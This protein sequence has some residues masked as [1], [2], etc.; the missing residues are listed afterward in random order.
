[1]KPIRLVIIATLIFLIGWAFIEHFD[2]KSDISSSTAIEKT[3]ENHIELSV[4][5]LKQIF[6]NI[7]VRREDIE[8]EAEF[9]NANLELESILGYWSPIGFNLE[10]LR[11]ILG[12]PDSKTPTEVSYVI[13]G[14]YVS[15]TATFKI[16]GGIVQGPD[17]RLDLTTNPISEELILKLTERFINAATGRKY[18]E[19]NK[20]PHF[21]HANSALNNLF[22]FWNPDGLSVDK[23]KAMIGE[24]DWK[25]AN[26]FGYNFDTGAV[27]YKRNFIV[28]EG[29]VQLE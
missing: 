11:E 20:G 18:L 29:K 9:Y 8:N 22:Y 2:H 23:L 21:H 28:E 6:G 15:H 19:A 13:R 3:P 4:E 27:I 26:E 14:P 12:E 10:Q 17:P 5:N 7:V 24:P 25:S 1:M 16:D